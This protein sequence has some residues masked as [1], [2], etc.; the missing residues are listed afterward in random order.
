MSSRGSILGE[1]LL[2]RKTSC[3]YVGFLNDGRRLL[4]ILTLDYL[5]RICGTNEGWKTLAAYFAIESAQVGTR[6]VLRRVSNFSL[7]YL[8]VSLTNGRLLVLS[9][10]S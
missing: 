6:F 2:A 8:L 1:P 3:G 10:L 7:P 9:T 4:V 5:G